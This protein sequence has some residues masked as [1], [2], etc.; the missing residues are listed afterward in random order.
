MIKPILITRGIVILPSSIDELDIGRPKSLSSINA[1]NASEDKKIVLVSQ[2][3]PSMDDPTFKDLYKVGTLCEIT[4]TTKCEDG[5]LKIVVKG[6]KR[7]KIL[8][9]NEKDNALYT[10]FEVIRDI[11]TNSPDVEKRLEIL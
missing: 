7:V 2:T 10:N 8:S 1:T 3:D 6:I 5:S 4:K 9:V 11:N